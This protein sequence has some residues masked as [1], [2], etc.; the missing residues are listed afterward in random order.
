MLF[1]FRSSWMALLIPI[2]SCRNFEFTIINCKPVCPYINWDISQVSHNV[3]TEVS[4]EV[5]FATLR[6]ARFPLSLG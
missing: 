2:E 5:M 4:Q 6:N 3:R 1:I